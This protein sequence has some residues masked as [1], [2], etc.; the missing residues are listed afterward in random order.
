[1]SITSQRIMQINLSGD[2]TASLALPAANNVSSPGKIDT[3]VLAVGAN[4]ITVPSIT[5]FITTAV[6]IIP[7]AG[8]VQLITLKGIAGDTG[9]FLHKTDPTTIALDSSIVNFVLNAVAQINGVRLV[10]S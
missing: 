7:P 3:L 9:V 10:W 5:G 8:N 6:T 4:T 1:M 2:V